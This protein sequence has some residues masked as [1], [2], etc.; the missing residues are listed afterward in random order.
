M[1]GTTLESFRSQDVAAIIQAAERFMDSIY[2]RS[3]VRP[4]IYG[5]T[6]VALAGGDEHTVLDWYAKLF[7]VFRVAPDP[8]EEND[9]LEWGRL[10]LSTKAPKQHCGLLS[11]NLREPMS[12]FFEHARGVG[13][14]LDGASYIGWGGYTYQVLVDP[15]G[16]RFAV[17]GLGT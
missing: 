7:N 13:A 6:V 5:D 11:F 2:S 4:H 17:Y 9:C 16:N 1:Y 10:T 8:L 3:I 14:E 12:R 15:W